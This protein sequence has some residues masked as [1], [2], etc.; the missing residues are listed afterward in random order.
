[1]R[2]SVLLLTALAAPALSLGA[3]SLGARVTASDGLVQVI[4]PSRP[5]VC[6]DGQG[7]I[8]NVLG[9]ATYYAGNSGYSGS[10]SWMRRACVEGP[11]RVVATVMGGEVTRIR[12]YVGPLPP[13]SA[14]V[15]TINAGATEAAG[16]LGEIIASRSTGR[17]ASEA[18]LPLLVADTPVPWPLFLRIA[19][20]ENRSRD[21][22]G[23][24][25][26]WL[27]SGVSDHLGIAD[28]QDESPDDEMRSQAV[29]VLSQ[30]PKSESVP[31]LIELARTAKHASARR[32]A[33][34]W[35]GQSG[36]SRAVDVYAELLNLR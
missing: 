8:G 30:R 25:M 22:R 19:K 2:H 10:G 9:R 27:A 16:W 4:Y 21:V 14:D 34:F 11:A 36:D 20:D 28:A 35:L 18:M 32:A 26:M 31:E 1:M 3:Q 15:K 12:S 6:G 7:L 24:A 23:A 33:I 17:V 29:F 5:N 13:S